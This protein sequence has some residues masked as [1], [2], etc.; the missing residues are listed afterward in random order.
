[1]AYACAIPSEDLDDDLGKD[2]Y[3]TI[4]I[5]VKQ[6]RRSSTSR[7]IADAVVEVTGR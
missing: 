1:V 6:V 5:L 3:R 4:G 2:A 7:W